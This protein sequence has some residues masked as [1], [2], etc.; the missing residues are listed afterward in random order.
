MVA[1]SHPML[2]LIMR[3]EPRWCLDHTSST[4][5]LSLGRT[6]LRADL[7]FVQYGQYVLLKTT[8]LLFLMLS[9]TNDFALPPACRMLSGCYSM[10]DMWAWRGSICR[11]DG[12][13]GG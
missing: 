2:P 6:V 5:N 13:G 7:A 3:H 4:V 12:P 10:A 11:G 1:G 9:S 8:T